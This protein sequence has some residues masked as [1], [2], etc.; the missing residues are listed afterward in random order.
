MLPTEFNVNPIRVNPPSNNQTLAIVTS[1]S[2][3]SL[4]LGHAQ[5]AWTKKA[6]HS[7]LAT[8]KLSELLN[9]GGRQLGEITRLAVNIGPGSFTGIRVGI[10]L[11][12]S[13][14]YGL[15]I[16]VASFNTLEVLAAK[17]L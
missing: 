17:H 14:A 12:R 8:V 6:M 4:A 11:A 9:A 3:G 16:P 15:G 1:G 10:N 13:L 5:V 2:T 7:E